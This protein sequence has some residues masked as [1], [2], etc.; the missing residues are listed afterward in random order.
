[1]D[2][3]SSFI[4]L[5]VAGHQ[6]SGTAF[7]YNQFW[8]AVWP[9]DCLNINPGQ[10]LKLYFRP[11]TNETRFSNELPPNNSL[12]IKDYLFS[13]HVFFI[14]GLPTQTM[15][16]YCYA[17]EK[18]DRIEYWTTRLEFTLQSMDEKVVIPYLASPALW[19]SR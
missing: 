3:W 13:H 1:M 9:D 17:F 16:L 8:P 15:R 2:Y 6:A 5:I 18:A 7:L 12:V 14:H 11:W 19:L 4:G 10:T